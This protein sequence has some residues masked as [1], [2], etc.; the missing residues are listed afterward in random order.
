[1]ETKTWTDVKRFYSEMIF[2]GLDWE[3]NYFLWAPNRQELV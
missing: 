1:M 2:F 3:A